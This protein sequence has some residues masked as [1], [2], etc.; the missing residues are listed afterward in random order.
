MGRVDLPIIALTA[1]ARPQDREQSRRAGMSGHLS[2]PLDAQELLEVLVDAVGSRGTTGSSATA[3]KPA[4]ELRVPGQSLA[5]SLEAFGGEAGAYYRLVSRFLAQQGSGLAQARSSFA[6][7]DT[8]GA[9]QRIHSLGGM[10]GLLQ[11]G[12]LSLLAE[13]AESAMRA[14]RSDQLPDLFDQLQ[15]ALDALSAAMQEFDA[16][17]V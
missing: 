17:V 2:K 6:V 9:S 8:E 5:Q 16:T 12:G 11:M 4:P 7:G 13:A 1:F 15:A 14:G 10:A 3:S